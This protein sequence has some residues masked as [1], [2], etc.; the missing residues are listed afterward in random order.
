[1]TDDVALGGAKEASGRL[2]VEIEALLSMGLPNSP[3]GRR[4]HPR[5][6]R[7]LHHREADRRASTASISCTPAKCARSTRIAIQKRLDDNELVLL[8]PLGYSPTGE[9]FNLALEDV[10]AAAAIALRREKL[11]FLMDTPG[12]T[13]RRGELL[14]ELTV[15]QAEALLARGRRPDGDVRRLPAAA[16]CAPASR[17]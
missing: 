9:V 5:G 1:M 13:G 6:E 17:A 15:K 4:R 11:I 3:D 8:S 10:A 14:R 12:V 7:Q 2:R 16:R